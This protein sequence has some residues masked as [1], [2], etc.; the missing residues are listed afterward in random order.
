M[1]AFWSTWRSKFG[2][3]Q[4][5]GVV[6][7]QR[8]ERGIADCFAN[9]FSSTCSPNSEAK[10]AKLRRRF[11]SRFAQYDDTDICTNRI[12]FEILEVCIAELKKGKAPGCDDL[13]AEHNACSPH[14][15]CVVIITVQ[16][17]IYGIYSVVPDTFG[18]GIAT[19][20]VKTWMLIEQ[21]P[22]IIDV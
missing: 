14:P 9:V 10:H 22:I 3:K 12:S 1:T 13:T 17:D 8:D 5:S 11:R 19:P 21:V 4:P 6:D 16:Y 7:G 18:V 2:K 20:L 15:E